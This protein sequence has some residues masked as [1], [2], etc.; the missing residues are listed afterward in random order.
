VALPHQWLPAA[1]AEV[2]EPAP[3]RDA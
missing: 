1:V 3:E 2:P